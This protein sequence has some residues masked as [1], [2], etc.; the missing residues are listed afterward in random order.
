MAEDPPKVESD[1][2]ISDAVRRAD[3]PTNAAREATRVSVT[4]VHGTFARGAGWTQPGSLLRGHL[5]AELRHPVEFSMFPWSG[6]PFF[7]SRRRAADG[8]REHLWRQIKE[9][10][11]AAQFVIAHSHGGNIVLDALTDPSLAEHIAGVITLSTP[12]L[13]ARKRQLSAIGKLGLISIGIFPIVCV[14]Y[15]ICQT[16]NANLANSLLNRPFEYWWGWGLAYWLLILA[17]V[18]LGVLLYSSFDRLVS[19]SGLPLNSPRLRHNQLFVVRSRSDEAGLA[20]TV[21]QA[22]G[23]LLTFLWGRRNWLDKV[24]ERAWG[25]LKNF[26]AAV[27]GRKRIASVGRLLETIVKVSGDYYAGIHKVLIV[28]MGSVFARLLADRHQPSGSAKSF[29]P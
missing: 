22:L 29:C 4:L 6:W 8:L 19:W 16:S 25:R 28:L 13:L 3:S 17:Y 26:Y 23:H 14:L 1:L 21:A 9:R 24:F 18:F 2:K 5:E 7:R 11:G 12:F 10:P 15:Y 27:S 20:L